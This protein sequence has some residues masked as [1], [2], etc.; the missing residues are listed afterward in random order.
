MRRLGRWRS[1]GLAALLGSGAVVAVPRGAAHAAETRRVAVLVGNNQGGQAQPALHYAEDDVAKVAE[2]L[3]EIGGFAEADVHLMTGRSLSAVRAVLADVKQLVA[4]TRARGGRTV[5]LFYFSGHSDGEGL[6][7]GNDCWPFADVRASLK[8]LGPDIRIAIVDSCQ[9]G[10]L[11]AAKGGTPGPTFDIRFTDDLA[12]AGEAV[13]TSSAAHERALESREIRASFFSHHFVSG[14]RGAAD[15]SNDG[16]VTLGEAYRYAFVNTLLATS[17]TL[18]GPQHPAYDFRL[19]GQG[20]L[21]LTEVVAHGSILSLPLGFD[22][23]LIA[24]ARRQY[25]LAELTTTSAH[26]IA[27]PAGRYVVQ[28]RRRDAAYE[29]VVS[30]A[31]G[32]RRA[33]SV[34]DLV[35]GGKAPAAT[36]GGDEIAADAF[37]A[38]AATPPAARGVMLGAAG[39]VTRG[40]ADALPLLPGA[41]LTLETPGAATDARGWAVQLQLASGRAMGFRESAAN[42]AAGGFVARERR[43]WRVTAG[44]RLSVGGVVQMIDRG[45]QNRWTLALGTGP[46]LTGAVAVAPRWWVTVAAGVD[47]RL[48]RGDL[49]PVALWP[50][51]AAGVAWRL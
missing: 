46:W 2:V 48:M 17:N 31:Q 28:A 3:T 4:Q 34:D 40:A 37:V 41:Q 50:S 7:L 13:L 47:A 18:T 42:L 1:W 16:R 32:E 6:E 8:D 27:L 35:A 20:E 38:R 51:V 21:V 22:R 43:R 10:A 23:I 45:A 15:S 5:L 36:K 24:D 26:R 9:S 11:L 19:S 29:A 39:A 12:T 49:Q 44:W 33:L 30:L 25:V 14:L